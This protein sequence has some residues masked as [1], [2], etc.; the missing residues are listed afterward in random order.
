MQYDIET[1]LAP[2]N[3][4][5]TPA[6]AK[7]YYGKYSRDGITGH[8]WG[9]GEGADQHD[10]IVNYFL[11]QGAAGVKSVNYVV[12]D[13]KITMMVDPDNV[14]W[15]SQSGNPT[16]ISIEMQPTLGDE[17]YKRAGW[18][19]SSLEKRYGKRLT[20]YRH[21]DWFA[22]ACPGTIDMD[23]IRGEA[24][25]VEG[26]TLP[27]TPADSGSTA[28]AIVSAGNQTVFLPASA[29]SWAAYKP[30][31]SYI[32]GSADQVGS[33]NPSLFGGLTYAVV[34]NQGNFVVIDTR[35]F[36]RVAIYVAAGSGAVVTSAAVTAGNI[37]TTSGGTVTFPASADTW[38]VYTVDS[39][40]RKGTEDQVGTLM[41]SQFGGLTYP[42]IENRGNVVVIQT[43]DFGQVAAWV[44]D[45]I[46][47]IN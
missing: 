28:E 18:L 32:K 25:Q 13:N 39:G 20:F 45:T 44:Q 19:V 43:R 29:T 7:A 11:A 24:D 30:N 37:P 38:A 41:P 40:Y 21:S 42:I 3:S 33:L 27:A 4:W 35:D 1:K 6:E 23:R 26:G 22:T 9:G 8:W 5:H 14:A 15:C 31:S 16:T 2:K 47:V 46:A 17:G 34:E 10:D 36:G 12:S